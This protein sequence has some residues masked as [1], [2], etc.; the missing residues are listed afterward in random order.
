MSLNPLP[1]LLTLT[2]WPSFP[3][4]CIVAPL[5]SFLL[6][7]QNEFMFHTSTSSTKSIKRV[8]YYSLPT[9]EGIWKGQ[10]PRSYAGLCHL[11]PFKKQQAEKSMTSRTHAQ[12]TQ[13]ILK[14]CTTVTHNAHFQAVTFPQ[15]VEDEKPENMCWYAQ[16]RIFSICELRTG[17]WSQL[18]QHS[19]LSQRWITLQG[20]VTWKMKWYGGKRID[21][22]VGSDWQSTKEV[23]RRTDLEASRL[24]ESD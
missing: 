15:H 19:S 5:C 6:Q 18:C 3:L 23:T 4:S 14:C 9:A 17:R 12:S 10:G 13:L 2:L 7:G 8:K 21:P 22:S 1:T 24:V 16:L 20:I 11:N